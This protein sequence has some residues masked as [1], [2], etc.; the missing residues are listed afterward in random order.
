MV[1]MQITK[2][3]RCE[4]RAEREKKNVNIQ[5]KDCQGIRKKQPWKLETI[6]EDD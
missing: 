3:E 5:A 4:E 2:E 6:S 1:R